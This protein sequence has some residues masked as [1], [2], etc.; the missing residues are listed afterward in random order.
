MSWLAKH[1]WLLAQDC[2]FAWGVAFPML[3]YALF[4]EPFCG[5]VLILLT[6][7]IKEVTFDQFVEHDPFFWNG[8]IDL[9]F[10]FAGVI[11]SGSMLFLAG[12]W[13]WRTLNASPTVFITFTWILLMFA[14]IIWCLYRIWR[15]LQ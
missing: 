6:A 13:T 5:S 14:L 1:I 15:E 9:S 12:K 3:F 2:H 7:I 10:Y 11:T 8:V 4:N